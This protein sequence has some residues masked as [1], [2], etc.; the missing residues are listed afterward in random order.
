MLLTGLVAGSYPALY[1]S[2]LRPVSVLKGIFRFTR[3]AIWLR[4]SL[5]VFQFVL[6]IVLMIATIVI[7]RQIDYVQ[8]TNLGYNRENLVYIRVEGDLSN[9]DK[10]ELFK[11]EAL[12]MPGIAMV[13]RSSETPHAMNFVA[14]PDA[15]NWEGKRKDE[16]VG[17]KPASVGFEF[18]KLMDLKIVE[19]RDFSSQNPTDSTD[20]FL[21]N[22]E[23]VRQMGF[24]QPLG[25]AISAWNKKGHIIGV[26]K[27]Y[28][29]QSFREPILPVI[30]D[31]KEWQDFGVILIR[32]KPGQTKEAIA[33]L[34]KVYKDVN[35]N[36]AF[37]WEFVDEQ[38]K[39]LY[40]SEM[41]ISRLSVLFASLAIAIS[42]LGLFGLVMF[43]AEQRTKEI[44]I[45]KVLGASIG[46]II[47]IFS[48]DFLRLI[49]LA[50]LIAGPIGWYFMKSW[51]HD[52]VYRID[53]SWW[54]FA[55]AG[56]VALLIAALTV[57]Y[58]AIRA[59]TANPVSSLRSE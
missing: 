12:T 13:D 53:I 30:V 6:S 49:L 45:R 16:R 46:Q 3:G 59:A 29:T 48:M 38:Y 22:E 20:G 4:K 2:S 25:K 50:F 44:G 55:L 57:S 34:A 36:Y 5:T 43:S 8:N 56:S 58:Q 1:L 41:L 7:I 11:H 21:V 24:K 47:G 35:P 32:T 28:H 23:A 51:L 52:F 17:F 33:S 39:Q 15:I 42:G 26:L 10:Y 40:N 19:G 18:V 54:I 14:D 37:S 9:M 31:V 27:D